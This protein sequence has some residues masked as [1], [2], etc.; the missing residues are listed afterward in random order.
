M[1]FF[2]HGVFGEKWCIQTNPLESRGVGEVG[3]GWLQNA[4]PS[5]GS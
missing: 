1:A 3:G 5:Q 4:L 2:K